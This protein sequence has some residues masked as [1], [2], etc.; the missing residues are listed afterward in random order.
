MGVAKDPLAEEIKSGST[1]HLALDELE[2]IDLSLNWTIAPHKSE[3]S[4]DR[5]IVSLQAIGKPLELTNNTLS[6]LVQ[7]VIQ[8]IR[9][10]MANHLAE[11]LGQLIHLRCPL[12]NSL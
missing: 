8:S 4:F 9:F 12:A 10:S 5:F 6:G 1:V 11:G 2:P 7:P 3:R